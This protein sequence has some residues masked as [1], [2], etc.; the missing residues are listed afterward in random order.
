MKSKKVSIIVPVFK[1]FNIEH[2]V[3][4]LLHKV[5]N[6]NV[7]IIIVDGDKSGSTV[8]KLEKYDLKT[9]KSEKGRGTQLKKGAENSTG[10][11]L[12]FL[13]ADTELPDNFYSAVTDACAKISSCGAFSL[14]IDSKKSVYR[15]IEFFANFRAKY[16]Q[17]PFG[18]QAIFV[19]RETYFKS[20]GFSE[21]PLFEDVD[22][23][24]KLK[25]C[26]VKIHISKD[27][28]VTSARRWQNEGVF[29]TTMCNWYLQIL[30]FVFKI[31]P[32]YL[33]KFYRS[34]K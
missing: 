10:D 5:Q 27:K 19:E 34:H 22:L 8:S 18:D 29:K 20:G 2:F 24:G 31:D 9:I 17:M 26:R 12:L 21:I 3:F 7:E 4:K 1:E 15:V 23:V 30:Y 16:L 11:I 28:V 33:K 32:H 14:K 25:K 6:H 13:H